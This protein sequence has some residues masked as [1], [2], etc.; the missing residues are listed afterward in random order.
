MHYLSCVVSIA[1]G[2]LM[3]RPLGVGGPKVRL[4]ARIDLPGCKNILMPE[5]LNGDVLGNGKRESLRALR[6]ESGAQ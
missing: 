1:P 2:I 5:K 4:S 3:S 6:E